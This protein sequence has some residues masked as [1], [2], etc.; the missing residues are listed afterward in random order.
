MTYRY[1]MMLAFSFFAA[2]KVA[3]TEQG[4]TLVFEKVDLVKIETRDT[5]QRIIISGT[6]DE[7][8]L[9]Y[10]QRIAIP[11][12]T[13][14]RR[15]MMNVGDFNR[16]C[17]HRRDGGKSHWGASFHANFGLATLPGI[18]NSEVMRGVGLE[19][20]FALTADWNPF[21][22]KNTWRAGLGLNYRSYQAP[23]G[24][25]WSKEGG[26][27]HLEP[28]S[29]GL[30]H[31]SANLGVYSLQLP[32]VC[33]HKFDSRGRWS[34][35]LGALVNWNFGQTHRSYEINKEDYNVGAAARGLRPFTVEGLAIVDVPYLPPLYV[36]Y[37]PMTV[38]KDG[39]GPKMRQ[40]SFGI[41]F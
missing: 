14:V 35:S 21:G 40:L 37:A 6:K 13:A 9:H 16:R 18:G 11:D 41:C 22:K 17:D 8:Q 29:D 3:A 31:C 4:D 7:R 12:T 2:S 30:E 38:F 19:C 26:E 39:R 5:V 20:G 27:M 34:V 33:T 10:L 1:L 36:R 23:K 15:H 24:K 25:Y 28:F 32:I